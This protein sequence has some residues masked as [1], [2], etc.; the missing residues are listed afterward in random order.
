LNLEL[1][2]HDLQIMGDVSSSEGAIAICKSFKGCIGLEFEVKLGAGKIDKDVLKNT[3]ESFREK[4][5]ET[6][7]SIKNT[8]IPKSFVELFSQTSK[9]D[10]K[11]YCRV[12]EISQ[13]DLFLLIYNCSQIGFT[14]RGKFKKFT[15]EQFKYESGDVENLGNLSTEEKDRKKIMNKISGTFAQRR[16]VSCHMFE[17]GTM[18][19]CF[20]FS[21]EDSQELPR[22]RQHWQFG[23]HIHY[24]SYLWDSNRN[25]LWKKLDYRKI[26]VSDFHIKYNSMDNTPLHQ[27]Y[28]YGHA[29]V[30]VSIQNKRRRDFG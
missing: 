25:E 5:I 26:N 28:L 14:H 1:T 27:V 10:V 13:E 3:R 2:H 23:T 12:L 22:K 15:P 6:D 4:L 19:H 21:Y 20:Y 24:V 17:N 8:G 29:A 9:N 16:N 7:N 18:W 30:Q 11:K